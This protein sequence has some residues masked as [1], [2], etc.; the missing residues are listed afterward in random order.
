M[1]KVNVWIKNHLPTKRRLIQLYAALL[2]NAHV[3]GFVEG[4]I[5]TGAAKAVCVPG[6]NCYSCPGAVGACPLGALQNALGSANVRAPYYVLG[7]L[8]LFGLTLGR[9]VC[10]FLCPVGMIQELLHKIPTPKVK[11]NRLTRALSHVKY[12]LLAVFVI[13]IPLYQ[14]V[15]GVPLPAFCKYICPAGTL[16]GAVGLLANGKNGA[17]FSMLGALFANKFVILVAT[18]ALCVFVFRA[19][20]R[21]ICPL[22]A[23]YSLFSRV[24]LL[25]VTVDE[26]RC[27]HCG[28]CVAHCKMDVKC[29]GDRECIQCG[30]CRSVCPTQCIHW[31]GV[32]QKKKQRALA[33]VIAAVVLVSALVC[34]NQP[35]Q[36][37]VPVGYEVGM[38]CP[39]FTV[40]VYGGDAFVLSQ[41]RG[42]VTVINFWATWCTP[43]INELPYFERIGAEY[44]EDVEMICIHSELVTED[45]QAWIDAR[46]YALRFA[47]DE[48]GEVIKSL[49]GSTMLPMT[50]IVDQNGTIV[51]NAV[52][53]VTYDALRSLIAPL[54]GGK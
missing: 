26:D 44:G 16:E 35:T 19:F 10:G 1:A 43:C 54:T 21:F 28:R 17:L 7:I 24:A 30:E 14:A 34:F 18:L 22:G 36:E 51:Y 15:K 45:V 52:G 53:S 31:K 13:G 2:Y 25:G 33:W 27:V 46:D 39:D 11:K 4:Q 37:N 49:G 23:I 50:V 29:V 6:L 8:L 12:V 40:P 20:C 38:A 41:T 42:K 48:T 47:L 32:P 5:Y 3:K 9:V